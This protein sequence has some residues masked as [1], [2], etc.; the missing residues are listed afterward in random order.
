MRADRLMQAAINSE[1]VGAL[2]RL[3]VGGW[4]TVEP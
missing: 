3:T 4:L 1:L 2:R